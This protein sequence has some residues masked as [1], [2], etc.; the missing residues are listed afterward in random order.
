M[1]KIPS[2]IPTLVFIGKMN[3]GKS[4]LIN[5]LTNQDISIVSNIPGTTTDEVVK[6]FELLD[7]G[8][9]NIIDT[10]GLNDESDLG[11]LRV[12]KTKKA[13]KRA[14][15]L[16]YVID[17]SNEIDLSEYDK[18]SDEKILVFNKIDL[19]SNEELDRLKNKYPLALFLSIK[20]NQSIISFKKKLTKL[21][22]EQDSLLLSNINLKFN[23]IVHVIPI[24]SEAPKGRII[25]PQMQL[26]RECLDTDLISIVLKESELEDYLATNNDI[27]L[28]VTDSQAFKIV[29]KINNHRFCLTSY[30]ILQAN[31]KGDLNYFIKSINKLKTLTNNAHILLMES[32]SHNASHEDIGRVKIPRILNNIIGDNYTFDFKMSHDFPDNLATYDY[33]IHCGSCMLSAKIMD[34][35][36]KQAKELNIPM[37][38]YG[39]IFAYNSGILEEATQMFKKV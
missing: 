25:L 2:L 13:I 1:D 11:I 6:R 22:Q 12:N 37:T 15:L 23:K 5:A 31:Q 34:K 38:N 33:I 4:S 17:S 26:I 8:P 35:R 29:S 16:V 30:S 39:L 24:D 7:V 32:C 21:L 3:S 28:I 27:G 9:I 18:L 19:L 36:I 14:S 20:D 10:A